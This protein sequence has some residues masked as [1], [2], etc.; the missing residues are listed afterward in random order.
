M[1]TLDFER[2]KDAER[3]SARKLFTDESTSLPNALAIKLSTSTSTIV[4]GATAIQAK[5]AVGKG[6]KGRLMTPEEKKRVVEALTRAKTAEEV[7]RLERMLA[8][9]LIPDGESVETETNGEAAA[10]AA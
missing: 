10:V 6:G 3:E 9:G 5:S 4:P 8:E 7:R 1:R 2:I